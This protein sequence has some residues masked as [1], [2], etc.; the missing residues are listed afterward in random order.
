MS[1]LFTGLEIGKSALSTHQLW[2]NII[3]H[4]I[5]NV[6]TPGYT[7]QRV[8][9]TTSD[10][11]DHPVGPVGTGV[12][13]INV[14]HIRDLF[15]NQQYRQDNRELGRWNSMN[16]TLSQIESLFTEP[17]DESLGGILN[18]FW[19][20]W[21]DLAN[22]PENS[23][24]R[25]S[26]VEKTNLL[27]AAFH[28]IYNRLR[29]LRDNVDEEI[30]LSVDAIN[31]RTDE[32]ASLN[33]Q[34][35]RAEVGGE[36]AND[37]RDK[38]D[39]LIDELS[40]YVD[41]NTLEMVNGQTSVY[42]GSQAIV[43]GISSYQLG[44]YE[45]GAKNTSINEVVWKGTKRSVKILNG[46]IKGSIDLRDSVIPEYMQALD[47][48]AQAL[49]T[50]VNAVHQTGY[51]LDGST[52]GINF[53]SP[54]RISAADICLSSDITNDI[55]NIAASLSGEV[56]DNRN[57]LAISDLRNSLLLTRGTTTISSFY[58]SLIGKIGGDTSESQN[59]RDDYELLVAQTESSRQSVQGVSL[60]EEMTQM[61]KYQNAF[62]A[63]ARVI[64]T[65]DE[66]LD[67]VINGMGVVGR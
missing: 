41:V 11:F 45:T 38:R 29:T 3:G 43:D 30:S 57:A 26:L 5:A 6:N 66:A 40:E 16:K 9:M 36:N 8:S 63:A 13:A 23:G 58:Q 18:D 21:S 67:T 20:S 35:S 47:D 25:N 12:K 49:V 15:L 42:I 65:M 10:P 51:S 1:G 22:Y 24:S 56:G 4:N 44:T 39:L 17:S 19:D 32:I 28:R 37:L 60:D 33:A 52:T 61:I 53:F 55:D 27:T 48:M 54:T 14:E 50:S 34:I 62:D 64:T 59:L 2:L 7:R 31:Q 46:Q